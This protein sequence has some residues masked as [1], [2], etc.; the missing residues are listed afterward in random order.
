MAKYWEE[1]VEM[2]SPEE[3]EAYCNAKEDETIERDLD[4]RRSDAKASEFLKGLTDKE[5]EE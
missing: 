2:R 5:D 4:T 1:Y 3:M